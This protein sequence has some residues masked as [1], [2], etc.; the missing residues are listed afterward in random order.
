MKTRKWSAVLGG[1]LV[2]GS[3]GLVQGLSAASA[4]AADA[5]AVTISAHVAQVGGKE[6]QQGYRDGIKDGGEA[7]EAACKKVNDDAGLSLHSGQGFANDQA[8]QEADYQ[9]G[10]DVG[11]QKA[12]D[13]AFETFCS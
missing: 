7:G 5:G 8:Q 3:L 2:V 1:A 6:Y 10:Y 11:Y 9:R 13:K 12:Y 4:M